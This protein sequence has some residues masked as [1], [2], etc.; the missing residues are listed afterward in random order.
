MSRSLDDRAADM[1]RE[2]DRSFANA[3]PAA[4]VAV[5]DLVAIRIGGDPFA[6]RVSEIA[7]LY[8]D[9]TLADVPSRIPELLGI[10]GFRGALVPVFDLAALL[11]YPAATAPRWIATTDIR[12]IGFAFEAFEA[13]LRVAPEAIAPCVPHEGPA[14]VRELARCDGQ[15]RPIVHL[16]SLVEVIVK[17]ALPRT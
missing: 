3:P 11:G 8:A 7:G 17:Q 15:V 1:R 6:L 12:A 10:V 4:V 2:F 16:S 9:R 5:H 13:H 14:H